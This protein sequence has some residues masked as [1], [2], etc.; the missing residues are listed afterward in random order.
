V[1]EQRNV[2]NVAQVKRW[3]GESGQYWIDNRER[4]QAEHERLTPHLFNAVG[5]SPGERILDIGCGCGETTIA[6]ARAAGGPVPG[7]GGFAVGLDL[8]APMLE[9]ARR[10][11]TQARVPNV[12]FL[13]GDAQ[14]CPLRERSCDAVISSFGI[15]FFDDPAAAFTSIA[16]SVCPTGRLA[17]LCWQ[18]EVHNELLAIPLRAFRDHAQLVSPAVGDLFF[19]PHRVTGLLATTGWRDIQIDAVSELAWVGADV[20]EVMTYVRGMPTI[21]ALAASLDDKALVERVFAALAGE[22]AG[23]QH[24][25]GVW[26]QAAAWLVTARRA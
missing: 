11:A 6:A 9:V 21:R 10:L 1:A 13:R 23:R 3:N 25:D 24:D 16:R 19:D 12:S 15:M 4:H 18:P 8:S 5:I 17:F 20:P 22:Y 2:P 26:V 7:S 14:A